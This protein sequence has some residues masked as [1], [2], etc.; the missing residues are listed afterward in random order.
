MKKWTIFAK[1]PKPPKIVEKQFLNN[2]GTFVPLY[3]LAQGFLDGHDKSVTF[4]L[5]ATAFINII[6]MLTDALTSDEPLFDIVTRVVE[7]FTR[8]EFFSALHT[9]TIFASLRT[10]LKKTP[11]KDFVASFTSHSFSVVNE[12]IYNFMV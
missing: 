7:L 3:L 6:I 5:S 8:P 9:S 1:N 11:K 2:F 10:C 12:P 4:P